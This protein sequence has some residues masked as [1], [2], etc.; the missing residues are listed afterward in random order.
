MKKILFAILLISTPAF[1]AD[2]TPSAKVEATG[3]PTSITPKAPEKPKMACGKDAEECQKVVDS[4]AVQARK[5]EAASA[6]YRSLLQGL[7]DKVAQ[8]AIDATN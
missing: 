5:W 8:D 2:D 1:A 7:G 3:K 6:R 4:V